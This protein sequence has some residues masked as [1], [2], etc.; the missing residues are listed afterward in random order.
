MTTNI[1][2]T[3]PWAVYSACL[4]L[5]YFLFGALELTTGLGQAYELSWMQLDISTA[6]VYPDVFGGLML[7]IIGIIFLFGISSQW[8]GKTEGA[9]FLVVG[10]LLAAVFFA[11]YTAIM[12]SH[13]VGFG[14]FHIVPE[15]YADIMADWAEWVWLDDLRPGIWLFVAA[16]PSLY[17]TLKIWKSRR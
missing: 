4:G 17:L 12:L 3:K 13:A 6:V 14:F 11:V 7:V 2:M 5:V 8:K 1:K 10:T 15:A 9:S 16:L